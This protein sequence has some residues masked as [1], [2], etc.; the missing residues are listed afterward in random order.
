MTNATTSSD[1]KLFGFPGPH[2]SIETTLLSWIRGVVRSN[3][4]LV[5]A[6]ERLRRS[7]KRISAG[8]SDPDALEILWQ[9][10]IALSDAHSSRNAIAVKSSLGPEK[11]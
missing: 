9:V 1:K 7:H 6:L 11:G 10:E 2:D 8:K 4:Q 5:Q 3:H